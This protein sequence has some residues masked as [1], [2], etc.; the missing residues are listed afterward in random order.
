MNDRDVSKAP[1][2]SRFRGYLPVVIDLETGGFNPDTDAL[3][4]LAAVI[5]EMDTEG[6]LVPGE[7]IFFNVDPFPGANVEPASLE[8]T[9]IDIDNPLRGAV[10]EA[11][12]LRDT[13]KMVRRELRAT[14]CQRAIVVAHNASFD[15]RF[16]CQAAD[17]NEIKRNPFHP[18]SCF[19]TATLGGLAYGQTVLARACAAAGIPFD[20]AE[21]HSALYDCDRSADLFCNI[22]NRWLELGGWQ[23]FNPGPQAT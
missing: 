7:R 9:G 4:E 22:V 21:A 23:D 12:A 6:R 18:F 10:H 8:F 11:K 20:A 19:D 14:G 17:R 2:A 1:I 5:L 13:F 15:Q 16:L 3:L